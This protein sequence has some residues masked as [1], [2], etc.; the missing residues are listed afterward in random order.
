MISVLMSADLLLHDTF[1]TPR[2][3]SLLETIFDA[4]SEQVHCGEVLPYL[5]IS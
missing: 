4:V 5:F 2:E 1:C 3:A